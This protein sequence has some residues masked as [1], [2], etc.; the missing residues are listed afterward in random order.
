LSELDTL[1]GKQ[2]EAGT[3][4]IAAGDEIGSGFLSSIPAI[5][6][7]I[8]VI[9]Q[10]TAATGKAVDRIAALP[11]G[12]GSIRTGDAWANPT[13]QMGRSA[14]APGL[15][16]STGGI[17]DTLWQEWQRRN[18]GIGGR[19][20]ATELIPIPK[21]GGAGGGGG[22]SIDSEPTSIPDLSAPDRTD[23][24]RPVKLFSSLSILEPP[25]ARED[26]NND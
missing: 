11:T 18:A 16:D 7:V 6:L 26:D 20:I 3:A 12:A 15:S 22:S 17:G 13:P 9:N 10:L 2:V 25:P 23:L 4:G 24:M 21:I 14:K 19:G 5:Q 8:G 1:V